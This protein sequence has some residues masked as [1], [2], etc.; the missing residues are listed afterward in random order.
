ML[1]KLKVI[2]IHLDLEG[3]KLKLG[4]DIPS[5]SL[6]LYET[7]CMLHTTRVVQEMVCQFA[8]Y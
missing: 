8:L 5:L 7:L 2:H 3:G 4:R 6:P 1:A